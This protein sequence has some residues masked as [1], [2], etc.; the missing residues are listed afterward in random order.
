MIIRY[1]LPFFLLF[2]LHTFRYANSDSVSA[3]LVYVDARIVKMTDA[4]SNG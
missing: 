4:K 3:F 2:F 1:V